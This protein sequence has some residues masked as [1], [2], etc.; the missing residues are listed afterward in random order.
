MTIYDIY[1]NTSN[2]RDQISRIESKDVDQCV[3]MV[4]DHYVKP[5]FHENADI[6]YANDDL[7]YL[8][9][10]DNSEIDENDDFEDY[11]DSLTFEIHV[12]DDQENRSFRVISGHDEFIT[13]DENGKTKT[14][15]S[16]GKLLDQ[17]KELEEKLNKN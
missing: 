15:F 11:E 17:T 6:D 13:L 4:L 16:L 2:G 3:K 5:E 10:I 8:T 14:P 9:I 7:T 1:E 12:S